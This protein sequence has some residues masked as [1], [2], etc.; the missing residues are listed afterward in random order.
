MPVWTEKT[1]EIVDDL[2]LYVLWNSTKKSPNVLAIPTIIK[3]STKLPAVKRNIN[4]VT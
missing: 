3:Y 1:I 4:G 2:A